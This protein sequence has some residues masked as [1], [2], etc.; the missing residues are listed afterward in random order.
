MRLT[1]LR[2]A[3]LA[4]AAYF[5]LAGVQ[6]WP[7]PLHLGTHLTGSPT[8]D[9]GVYVWNL[10]IFRHE[11]V[12]LGTTPF[13]TLEI[14]PLAGPTDLSL[15]NYTVFADVLALPLLALLD[16]V[17]AFNLIYLTNVA[18]AGVG[19][20]FLAKR[21]TGR[22]AESALAGLLFA[23]SPYLVTRGQAHF[24][25]VAIAPLPVFLLLL[26]R[27]WDTQRLREALLAGAALAWAAFCDPYYAIYCVLLGTAFIG[28][29]ILSVT[30]VRRPVGELRAARHLVNLAFGTLAALIVCVHMLGGGDLQFGAFRISMRTLYTPML[31]L[32]VLVIVRLLLSA[33]LRI[34]VLPMPP[35]RWMW[36]AAV[37]GGVVAAVLL[38]PTLLA[39]GTR[40]LDGRLVKAPVL[41]R[42]SAPGID[43]VSYVLPNPNHALAPPAMVG[44]LERGHGGF[45]DQ[46]AS[47]SW[48]GFLVILVAWR[49]GCFRPER[50]WL[51]ITLGFGLLALGPFLHVAGINTYIPTPWALLRYVPLIGEARMPSRFIAVVTLGFSV[52]F[53][54][55]LAGLSARYPAR[56]RAIL[57]VAGL[58][59]AFELIPAPRMLYAAHLPK[60]FEPIAADPRPVR[61]LELPTGVRDGLSSL[62]NFNA[63]T[64]FRQTLHGKGLIGGYL[65][66]VSTRR[67]DVY[68][69]MPVMSALLDLGE[70]RKLEPH[71]LNR[72]LANANNFVER[73]NLG[74]VVMD[75]ARVTADLRDFAVIIFGLEKV[76]EADGYE[77]YVP[78]R[79][80]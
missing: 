74:Y 72:A 34:S 33:N 2:Q 43:L 7:L 76:A 12:N 27:A 29:R 62:G 58:V 53:A 42:S 54:F 38:S 77:L 68:R 32:T 79:E 3:L 75:S 16:I 40:V 60:V 48:V 26:Y 11:L 31:M 50:L 18:L 65:S 70:G 44:W 22:V 59:L 24:S 57:G 41:W 80:R 14:L 15:H 8:G 69:T 66:R 6:A 56:R 51:W 73:T 1:S 19:M 71:K 45:A 10:W 5:A 47:L 25:L 67:K 36:R 61:V 35:Q 23:W 37:A 49:L 52:L 64:Q 30:F 39:V 55:A 21:L 20:F 4:F 63:S 46:V 13:Q 17:S 9:T 78:R 28:S